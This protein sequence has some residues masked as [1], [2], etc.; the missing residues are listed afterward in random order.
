MSYPRIIAHRGGGF[1][2]PENTLAGIA[3]SARL[4]RRGVEFDVML[5]RDGI[6][7]LMHDETVDRTTDGSGPVAELTLSELR[8]L[9]AGG[10]PVPT[11]AEA[12]DLSQSLGLWINVE[13]KP[14]SGQEAGTGE[15]T[16]RLL[17]ARWAGPGVV[18]S[19][20]EAALVAA[21]AAAPKLDYALLADD[22]PADWPAQLDRLGCRALHCQANRFLP[23]WA[24]A[25][26]PI[27]CYTVNERP[28]AE[29]LLAAGAAAVF[30]D[31]PDLWQAAEG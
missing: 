19:F 2:A 25:G 3:L 15:S 26:I 23:G 11:L 7:V 21:R 29:A 1:L 18:S 13:I 5:S 10:E 20:S 12:L 8:R 22:P 30:T 6:P 16:A 17:A 31:R 4:G 27:A 9:H 24:A 28:Q 14:G